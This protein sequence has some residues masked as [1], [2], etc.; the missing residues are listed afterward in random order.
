M[1]HSLGGVNI[2]F[3]C[4]MSWT[5]YF[6]PKSEKKAPGEMA[7]YLAP[8]LEKAFEI[9]GHLIGQGHVVYRIDGDEGTRIYR[10][11]IEER[12]KKS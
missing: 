7:S 8:T 11:I 12:L 4:F 10:E 1:K 9:S 6:G 3:P 2:G 5:I